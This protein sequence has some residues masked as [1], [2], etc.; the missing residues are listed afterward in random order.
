MSDRF[1]TSPAKKANRVSLNSF[2]DNIHF[3]GEGVLN[4]APHT[5]FRL[6]EGFNFPKLPPKGL[7]REHR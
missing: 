4:N 2:F 1:L 6:E 7:I 5:D 3:S